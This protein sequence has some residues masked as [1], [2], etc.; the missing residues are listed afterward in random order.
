[1]KPQ[2][3]LSLAGLL[4]GFLLLAVPG[5]VAA[6]QAI[7]QLPPGMTPA[8]AIELLRT[9]PQLQELLRQRL[10]SSGL[11]PSQIR[12][13][14]SQAGLDPGLLDEFAA[15]SSLAAAVD[16]DFLQ[17]MSL[18]GVNAFPANALETQDTTQLRLRA[19]SLRADR[20]AGAARAGPRLF[21]LDV[22][23][24]PTTLFQ[25]IVTGPVD[26]SYVLGPGD[27]VVLI[28]TGEVEL[29]HTLEITRGGFIVIPSV[30]QIHVNNLTLGQLREVLYDRLRRV[31]SGVSRRADA[32]THFDVTV[33]NVRVH[34]VRVLGEIARPGSYRL[35][36]TGT[37]LSALYEA[38]G[39]TERSNFRAIEIRRGR[40]RLAIVDLYDYLLKGVVPSDIKLAA[41]DVIFVP[42]RGRRVKMV[43]EVTRPAIYELRPEESLTDLIAIAGGFTP[44]AAIQT[45]TIDRILPPGERQ[46]PDHARTVISVNL[47]AALRA[48]AA[49]VPLAAGDSITVFSIRSGRRDAVSIRGSVWQPG[50]YRL[51]PDMR[52]SDLIAMAGGIRPETYSG[53][54]QILRTYPDSTQ[55]LIGVAVPVLGTSGDDVPLQERDEITLF[56]TTDFR[57]R[58]YL[59][60]HGAVRSPGRIAFAD[61]ITLRDAIL[62]AGGLTEDA[63]LREAEVSRLQL[64]NPDGDSIAVVFR[65]PLDSS[66]V[67][68]ET[69]YVARPVGAQRAPTVYLRPYDQ[70]LVRRQPGFEMPRT[71]MITGEVTYPGRYTL[72]SK[73]ERLAD[74]L[75]RAGGL[76]PQAYANGIRFFRLGH[77]RLRADQDTFVADVRGATVRAPDHA[78]RIGVD[79]PRVLRN[80]AHRDNL[81]LAAGDSIH[82]P[83]YMPYVRVQGAVNLPASVAYRRGAGTGYYVD[84]AGGYGRLADKRA[85]FVMQPNGHVQKGGDPEPGAVVIVPAMER[86]EP[87]TTFLQIMGALA[88]LISAATTI[89][90]VLASR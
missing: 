34:T 47:D 58:R 64:D 52:L 59:A 35:A 19:D 61:S 18:L 44:E 83:Q 53:R 40:E 45:A 51:E 81:V 16:T 71:V 20:I 75:A 4:F 82:I 80:P 66:Y 73:D 78:G 46:G 15:G 79:L 21:G 32:A 22:F 11:S 25:P 17:A 49:P 43:G 23:R 14:L 54:A 50:T 6:P 88:P 10:A 30:G 90:V 2:A 7:P 68:D 55:Q 5:A 65:A 37:V 38:G 56:A 31:Y 57:P 77:P 28:L 26:D 29:A 13:R 9:S 60:V 41:G 69:G 63:D 36:A 74:V 27:V 84:G 24:Q 62:L 8:Q 86:R 33:A 3:K 89:I 85:T 76:T 39:L 72:L 70:I 1:M 87:G 12:D 48:G 42:V 67:V